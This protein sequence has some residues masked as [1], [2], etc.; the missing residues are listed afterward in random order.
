MT[1]DPSVRWGSNVIVGQHAVIEPYAIIGDDVAIGHGV[2]IK[3][4]TIVGNRVTIGDLS[5]L[6]K[7]PSANKK[8]A[9]KPTAELPVLTIGEG[10]KIGSGCVIYRGVTL[11]VD[12]L[13]GDLA[14]IR[15][16]VEVGE[17]SIIG[18][19]VA[20]EPHTVI[21]SFVTIQTS[22]YIT[23]NMIIEDGVFI[24]PCCSTS[25]DKYMGRGDYP[26]LGPVIRK[27][28]RIG[29]NATLL[30]G[31]TIGEGAM[32]GAGAVITRDVPPY[33]T[34]VGNPGKPLL[35]RRESE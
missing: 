11:G 5:V 7:T 3:E 14:G 18:R 24:G 34:Y 35:E 16:Q 33:V 21:G 27:G 32:I 1:L 17:S 22:S 26:H 8:K 10:A 12:V 9:V 30:P 25:N 19:N 28:A 29:N 20:I 31:I 23:S 6:G 13:V 4:G 15:E 2:V